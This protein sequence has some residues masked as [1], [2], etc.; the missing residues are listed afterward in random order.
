MKV[1]ELLFELGFNDAAA[2]RNAKRFDRVVNDVKKNVVRLGAAAG[3]AAVALGAAAL[4]AGNDYQEMG[5]KLRL[6]S[7]SLQE[8]KTAQDGVFAASQRS[9]SSLQSTTDL[10]FG[11]SKAAER[12]G[13]S[14]ERILRITETTAKL[15]TMSGND[16]ASVDAA[17]F[18]LRQGIMSGQLRGQELNS[19]LEQATPVADA[20]AAGMGIPFEEIRKKAEQGLITG[21]AV[22]EA[23][24]S[25]AGQTDTQFAKMNR[26]ARQARQQ[27]KNAFGFYSGRIAEDGDAIKAQVEFWDSLNEIVSSSAFRGSL[28]FGLNAMTAIIKAAGSVIKGINNAI[29]AVG[30]LTRAFQLLGSAIL[31]VVTVNLARALPTIGLWAWYLWG[32]ASAAV[33]ASGGLWAV[34]GAVIAATWPILAII[35][36]VAVLTLAF[37]DLWSYFNG[38]QSVIIPNLIKA[39][40]YLKEAVGDFFDSFRD[41]VQSFKDWFNDLFAPVLAAVDKIKSGFNSLR[42]SNINPANWFSDSDAPA[43]RVAAGIGGLNGLNQS[44]VFSPSVNINVP[45]GT[46]R[47]QVDYM[48]GRFQE[49]LNGY[50]AQQIREARN[51]FVEIE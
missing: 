29:N 46:M 47:E 34:A 28:V 21:K 16:Q 12:Y 22:L 25:Q 39:W 1:R 20:I 5:N 40:G 31:A 30:G 33:A 2:T 3:A 48:D 43:Q 11:L 35:A 42:N 13:Y 44:N 38:G 4:K 17:L 14:Q 45:P 24:E 51:N 19:V 8:L 36:A 27:F 49:L 15:A 37:D 41:W 7:N 26:T 6:V 23:L 50:N 18:Q 10:Y 9:R 32:V